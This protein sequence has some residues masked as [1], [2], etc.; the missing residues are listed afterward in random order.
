MK[1]GIRKRIVKSTLLISLIINMMSLLLISYILINR[2]Q[3]KSIN[4]MI[5]ISDSAKRVVSN[6]LIKEDKLDISLNDIYYL[7]VDYI[8][9]Y[10]D[11]INENQ[12]LGRSINKE[13]I[14]MIYIESDNIRSYINS[15]YKDKDFI[16]TFN[17]PIYEEEFLGNF[18]LQKSFKD[19]LGETFNII[20]LIITN[21]L[22]F[23]LAILIFIN[24]GLFNIVK[25]IIDLKNSINSFINGENN[26][27]INIENKDEIYDLNENYL[28]LKNKII[29]DRKRERDFLSNSTHELKTPITAIYAYGQLLQNNDDEEFRS[30]AVSRILEESKKLITLIENLLFINKKNYISNKREEEV[31][32]K[33]LVLDLVK[34]EEEIKTNVKIL[35][36]DSK[37]NFIV[38]GNREEVEI[39]IYNLLDN[40]IKYSSGERIDIEIQ[41]NKF[42]IRNSLDYIP[43]D[44]IN[45][46][47]EPFI[48]YN[49][50]KKVITS[51][52]FGLYMAKELSDLNNISLN[53]KISNEK[54]VF[55]LE[56]K[57]TN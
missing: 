32:I 6:N 8:G 39:I 40:A 48:K 35:I 24:R 3:E 16:I 22:I 46:L 17:Y 31:N 2:F 42:I 29:S 19:D 13:E 9:I 10:K 7:G 52:G 47:F 1:I 34:K 55:N 23:T 57:N 21:Q 44:I 12:S 38:K 26:Y 5:E 27:I 49:K 15:V 18:I 53:Y 25:P 11:K 30:K 33:E 4:K 20:T 54:I 28:I 56:S 41:N 14:D 51:S 43:E 45:R 37:D 36:K 50:D